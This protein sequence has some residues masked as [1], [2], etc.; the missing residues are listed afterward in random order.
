MLLGKEGRRNHGR[1]VD[2]RPFGASREEHVTNVLKS[3]VIQQRC[4]QA[5]TSNVMRLWCP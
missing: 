2:Q 3:S 1:G 5:T 4:R